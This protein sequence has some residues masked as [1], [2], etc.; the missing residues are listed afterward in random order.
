MQLRTAVEAT[1]RLVTCFIL[2]AKAMVNIEHAS[3]DTAWPS[4]ND[5]TRRGRQV[6]EIVA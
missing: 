1:L 4:N 6:I 2:Y 3:A 5:I